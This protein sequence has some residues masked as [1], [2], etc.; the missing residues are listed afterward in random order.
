MNGKDKLLVICG[1]TA[2]G[3]TAT[4]LKL[5]QKYNAD[6]VSAD[7]R[8]IYKHMDIGTGKDIPE[9]S[10]WQLSDLPQPNYQL[11]IG[12]WNFAGLRLWGYDLISPLDEYSVA[13]YVKT[14]SLI[15]EKIRQDGKNVIVVGGTGLYIKALTDGIE[16]AIIP[17]NTK[18]RYFLQEL[19]VDEL[20]DKLAQ[21]DSI[22]AASLNVSDRRNPRRLVRALE[23]AQWKMKKKTIK[24]EEKKISDS[25]FIGLIAPIEEIELRIK[26]RI[27]K[28]IEAGLM[29]EISK[30]LSMGV[31]WNFQSMNTLGYK[32]FKN[33]FSGTVDFDEVVAEW[34]NNERR[35]VKR[36][37]TWFKKENRIN[38]F[39]I[40]KKDWEGNMEKVVEKWHNKKYQ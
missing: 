31:G 16:T 13:Q 14:A 28:R 30:L 2:T 3:K 23:I 36:Q 18:L 24:K 6:L 25:L 8:Q 9:G 15:I 22:K 35:Y 29:N 1:P 12:Y 37:I 4:A 33:Y 19:T 26:A 32:E 21:V 34:K 20:F 27:I 17:Q 38:W 39:D 40:T 7:S 5:A 10:V 11:P